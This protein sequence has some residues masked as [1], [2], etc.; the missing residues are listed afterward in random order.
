[1]GM[2]VSLEDVRKDIDDIDLQ[3]RELLMSRLDCSRRVAEAKQAAGSTDVYRADREQAM[4]DALGEGI[5]E[6]RRAPYL[7][8]VRKITETSRMYQYCL[9][10]EWN[11]GVFDEIEGSELCGGS[12][13]RVTVRLARPDQPCALSAILSMVGDYGFD[14]ELVE[15]VSSD[16]EAGTV[17]FDLAI[18]CDVAKDR[19][20]CLLFQLSKE[21]ADFRIVSVG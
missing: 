1:M 19:A 13:N 12:S 15:L 3:I 9:L 14:M 2:A 10:Y 7:S 21:S 6:E 18:R 8:V 16:K 5:P 11:P 4:L 17:T 20:R